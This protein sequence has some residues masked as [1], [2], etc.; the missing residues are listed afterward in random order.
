MT[1]ILL[2]RTYIQK[3]SIHLKSDYLLLGHRWTSTKSNERETTCRNLTGQCVPIFQDLRKHIVRAPDKRDIQDN[4][5][6]Q[7]CWPTGQN[8]A[9]YSIQFLLFFFEE[10]SSYWSIQFV[11]FFLCFNWSPPIS[12]PCTTPV[13][14]FKTMKSYEVSL[15]TTNWLTSYKYGIFRQDN[16]LLLLY[17]CFTS[18]ANIYGHVGTVS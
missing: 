6:A 15:V 14:F 16:G 8:Y 2:K 12:K 9:L 11:Q 18:T 1:D 13:F 5:I 3:S 7:Q 4:C 17:C 10:K